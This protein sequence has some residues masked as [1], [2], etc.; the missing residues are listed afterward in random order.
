M[1]PGPAMSIS[2]HM[3][4][5]AAASSASRIRAATSRGAR[6]DRSFEL[7]RDRGREIALIA[8]LRDVEAHARGRLGQPG[9]TQR[10]AQ[11]VGEA[12]ADHSMAVDLAFDLAFDLAYGLAVFVDDRGAGGAKG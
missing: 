8:V 12:V 7:E 5:A 3:S 6:S 10:G 9:A 1:N 11:G 4:T 2:T